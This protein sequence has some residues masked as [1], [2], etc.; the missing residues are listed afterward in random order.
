MCE[1]AGECR[2]VVS[3]G[4]FELN[5]IHDSGERTSRLAAT[6]AWHFLERVEKR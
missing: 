6:S 3:L 2:K 1:L 4:I 5:P